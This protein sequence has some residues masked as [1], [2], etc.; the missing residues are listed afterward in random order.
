MLNNILLALVFFVA[1]LLLVLYYFVFFKESRQMFFV[2]S[3]FLISGLA[4]SR[5][6]FFLANY[7]PP[8]TA[9]ENK[10]KE[11]GVV[12]R[13]LIN[14]YKTNEDKEHIL[15][16]IYNELDELRRRSS[17]KI[18]TKGRVNGFLDLIEEGDYKKAIDGINFHYSL[19]I[20]NHKKHYDEMNFLE[21]RIGYIVFLNLLIALFVLLS[22]GYKILKL[23]KQM[24]TLEL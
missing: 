8:P 2:A 15:K 10:F 22:L 3:L 1:P 13:D 7:E 23:R 20:S 19:Y 9:I 24:Y 4:I 6:L 16:M 12:I 5:G 17:N 21:R 11:S 14:Q 18:M